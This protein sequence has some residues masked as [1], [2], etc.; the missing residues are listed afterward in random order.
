MYKRLG[1]G[2]KVSPAI[3]MNLVTDMLLELPQFV[4]DKC[5]I[6][7]DDAILYAE[8]ISEMKELLSLLLKKFEEYGLLL[9]VNKIACFRHTVK[10]MGFQISSKDGTPTI[11]PLGSRIRAIQ[12][13]PTQRTVR[14]IKIFPSYLSWPSH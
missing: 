1:Q 10:Y 11:K 4:R 13:L 9:G 3:F 2:L 6:I 5:T 8:S 7:M 12:Q 14:G